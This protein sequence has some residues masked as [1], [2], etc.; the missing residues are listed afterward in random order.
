MFTFVYSLGCTGYTLCDLLML[1][2]NQI[3]DG[4][5]SITGWQAQFVPVIKAICQSPNVPPLKECIL[6]TPPAP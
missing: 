6:L 1:G 3:D 2:I 5:P 4:F